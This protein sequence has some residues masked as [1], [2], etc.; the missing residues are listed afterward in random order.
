MGATVSSFA[1]E[2]HNYMFGAFLI[3]GWIFMVTKFESIISN[4]QDL[5]IGYIAFAVAIVFISLDIY[6]CAT[7]LQDKKIDQNSKNGYWFELATNAFGG[8]LLISKLFT[9]HKKLYGKYR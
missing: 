4:G 2:A 3:A 5:L 9:A 7:I 6:F 1:V 8:I